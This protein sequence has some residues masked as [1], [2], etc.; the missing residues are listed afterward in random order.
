MANCMRACD[1]TSIRRNRADETM[2]RVFIMMWR[3]SDMFQTR[4]RG[5]LHTCCRKTTCIDQNCRNCLEQSLG[6]RVLP[7][8]PCTETHW[9][10][11]DQIRLPVPILRN[12][13]QRQVSRSAHDKIIDA[14]SNSE[15]LLSHIHNSS[16]RSQE[17]STNQQRQV[18]RR[19]HAENNSALLASNKNGSRHPDRRDEYEFRQSRVSDQSLPANFCNLPNSL[20]RRR[21]RDNQSEI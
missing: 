12:Q 5:L 9:N 13:K 18:F 14:S 10:I 4:S 3:L 1:A 19:N 8:S 16:G 2:T 15:R 17:I 20:S 6:P 21:R 7:L 11:L